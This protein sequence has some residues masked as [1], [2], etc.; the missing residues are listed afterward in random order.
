MGRDGHRAAQERDDKLG[1]CFAFA[2]SLNSR[3][4]FDSSFLHS[5]HI[6]GEILQPLILWASRAT[7]VMG[8]DV[9]G[10]RRLGLFPDSRTPPTVG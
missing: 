4:D 10:N 6:R 9:K 7:W 1:F 3:K 8:L 2:S 5:L